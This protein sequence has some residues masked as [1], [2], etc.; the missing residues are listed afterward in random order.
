ML[1]SGILIVSATRAEV[2]P[3]CRRLGDEF[4]SLITGVGS[5]ATAY[6][7][8]RTFALQ[9]CRLAINLGIAGSFRAEW[10]PGTLVEV[11]EDRFAD[12]G[13]EDH[14]AFLDAVQLGLIEAD[15]A[16]YQNGLLR[17]VA[18]PRPACM[19]EL[20]GARGI[21]LS[22]AHGRQSSI[23]AVRQ[24]LAPDTESME[25]A[26]FFYACRMAGVPCIQVRA[27]SNAV[28][29]RNREAWDIPFAI[30]S[31]NTFAGRMLEQLSALEEPW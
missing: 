29:P 10:Q 20:P 3:L 25:G 24:R 30:A 26:A 11:I 4:P 31:L 14:D 5:A 16:P 7:L 22:T 17:P 1:P 28:Q 21:T 23:D 6:A 27:I 2:A 9:P 15:T 18:G 12:L 19:D 13:A 8:G